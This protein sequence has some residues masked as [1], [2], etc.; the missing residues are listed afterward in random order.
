MVRAFFLLIP[1]L[2]FYLSCQCQCV[3]LDCN[4]I[5]RGVLIECWRCS[6]CLHWILMCMRNVIRSRGWKRVFMDIT[7][8][9]ETSACVLSL[10]VL[11][12]YKRSAMLLTRIKSH[13]RYSFIS[14]WINL[15]QIFYHLKHFQMKIP[16]FIHVFFSTQQRTER[17][18]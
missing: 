5:L 12:S 7:D 14:Q 6:F 10:F 13:S 8:R 11:L 1:E 9:N 17:K 3:R 4:S 2:I 16:N 15:L 18:N